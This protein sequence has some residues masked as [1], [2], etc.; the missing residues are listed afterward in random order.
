MKSNLIVARILQFVVSLVFISAVMFYIGVLLMLPL[1]VFWYSVKIATLLLPFLPTA[2]SVIIGVAVLGY[3]GFKVS[4][5]SEILNTVVQ[6]GVD[7]VEFGY[8]Q[9]ERFDP[10]IESSV[11]HN[12]AKVA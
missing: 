8:K 12:R 6:V 4:S 7:L 2:I 5:M 10:I 9:K 1:A 11:E 3:V